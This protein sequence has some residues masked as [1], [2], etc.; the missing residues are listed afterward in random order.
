MLLIHLQ[1]L[2]T[3]LHVHS[4]ASH[5]LC[6]GRE[7]LA[8]Q[9]DQRPKSSESLLFLQRTFMSSGSITD[10][11][12]AESPLPLNPFLSLVQGKMQLLS[13]VP[14]AFPGYPMEQ[15]LADH[16]TVHSVCWLQGK[17]TTMRS[18]GK[19]FLFPSDF[20]LAQWKSRSVV[21]K[22]RAEIPFTLCGN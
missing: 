10:F 14:A 9:W 16:F 22:R 8:L 20:W 5:I 13:R 17:E 18:L 1:E 19:M 2:P 7:P 4:S 3:H 21:N 6:E 12:P 11:H 15:Y